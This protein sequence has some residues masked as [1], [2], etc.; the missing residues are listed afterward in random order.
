[1]EDVRFFII[2]LYC[3]F[4]CLI[5][6]WFLLVSRSFL[7]TAEVSLLS[8]FDYWKFSVALLEF[9]CVQCVG[10]LYLHVVSY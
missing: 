10:V 9:S 1:M 7:H 3:L 8:I 4:I 5:Y 2:L 6:C